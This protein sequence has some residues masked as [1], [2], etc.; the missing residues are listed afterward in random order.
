MSNHNV[1]NIWPIRINHLDIDRDNPLVVSLWSYL[2]HV[3]MIT[4]SDKYLNMHSNLSCI[5]HVISRKLFV[6]TTTTE[7]SGFIIELII[8][9]WD[10]ELKSTLT[11]VTYHF[12]Q[13]RELLKDQI[14][15]QDNSH[16]DSHFVMITLI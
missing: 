2:K 14:S 9:F 6:Y 10:Q 15:D 3:C 8:L 7:L 13:G 4:W 16:P 5:L 12:R 11:F 1:P